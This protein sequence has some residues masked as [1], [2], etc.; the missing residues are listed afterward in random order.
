MK[1]TVF[2]GYQSCSRYEALISVFRWFFFSF[3]LVL[4]LKKESKALLNIEEDNL[5]MDVA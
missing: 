5:T 4:I 1:G 3:L 2:V